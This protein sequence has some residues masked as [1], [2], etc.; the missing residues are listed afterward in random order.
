MALGARAVEVQR[1]IV[2]GG[3]RLA[4]LAVAL[5][6]PMALA[7]AKLTTSLLYGVKAMGRGDVHAGSTA[8]GSGLSTRMLDTV[9]ASFPHRSNSGAK[10]R[11]AS[12]EWWHAS[13]SEK[14]TSGLPTTREQP[15]RLQ[16]G[17]EKR[18]A[19]PLSLFWRPLALGQNASQIQRQGLLI[20]SDDQRF[21]S[22]ACF[23]IERCHAFDHLERDV[24][25]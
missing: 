8:A 1:M 18:L 3:M 15:Q 19:L 6:L 21:L 4:L 11:L 9:A 13:F 16:C 25:G 23:R 12:F 14:L 2:R 24:C 20:L 5:G 7:A 10:G 22:W 17:V